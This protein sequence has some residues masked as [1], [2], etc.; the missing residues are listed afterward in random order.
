MNADNI[1]ARRAALDVADQLLRE[2]GSREWLLN[3]WVKSTPMSVR[4]GIEGRR[5]S[6][7]YYITVEVPRSK[8]EHITEARYFPDRHNGISILAVGIDPTVND[9][10]TVPEPPPAGV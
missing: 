5:A 9:I 10:P 1:I 2:L 8:L 4:A 7:L 3:V 6:R